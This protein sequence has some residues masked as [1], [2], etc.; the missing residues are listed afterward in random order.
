MVAPGVLSNDAD[1]IHAIRNAL[2]TPLLVLHAYGGDLR[3]TAKQLGRR[4]AQGDPLRLGKGTIEI[5]DEADRVED[6]AF[7]AAQRRLTR[8][9]S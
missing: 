9:W 7:G 6:I 3:N 4:D 2:D 5:V 8:A 1:V